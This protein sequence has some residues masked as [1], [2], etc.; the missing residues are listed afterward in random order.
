LGV[1]ARVALA[2]RRI[3]DRLTPGTSGPGAT[4]AVQTLSHLGDHAAVWT[5]LGAAGAA[6]DR[7]GRR[8]WLR[9]TGTVL[10]AHASA[11]V[12]KRLVRR[13]RPPALEHVT[14]VSTPS[15]HS[16]PSS[17]ATSSTAAAVAFG[18]LVPLGVRLPLAAAV[19]WSRLALGVHHPSDVLAGAALGAGIARLA[20]RRAR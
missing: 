9:A 16:F 6:L 19:S 10:A 7:D 4:R 18:G 12:I 20:G 3:L 1:A 13:T 11:S 17:H 15:A 5:A 14:S 8:L 2:E